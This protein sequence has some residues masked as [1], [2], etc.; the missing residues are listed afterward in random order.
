MITELFTYGTTVTLLLTVGA[1]AVETTAVQFGWSRRGIWVVTLLCSIVVPIA[2][3]VTPHSQ[4]TSLPETTLEDQVLPTGGGREDQDIGPETRAA[5]P[6]VTRSIPAYAVPNLDRVLGAIWIALS[7]GVT[8][9]LGLSWIRLRRARGTWR[10]ATIDG[11]DVWVTT[12][13]G[14]AV[15]GFFRPQILVP[16][17]LLDAPAPTRSIVLLHECEH[18]DSRDPLLLFFG[19]L[20]VLLTPWNLPLWWQLK[21]LRFAV[22]VD[23]DARVL[24]TGTPLPIYGDVLLAVSQRNVRAP[25]GALAIAKPQSELERRI[26]LMTRVELRPA[27][28]LIAA[29]LALAAACAAFALELPAPTLRSSPLRIPALHDWSPYLPKAE[30]AARAAYPELF[31]GRFNGTV[32]L[33]VSLKRDGA[34]LGTR[35][36]EFPPGPLADDALEFDSEIFSDLDRFDGAANRKFFGWFG[37][38]HRNGLYMYYQ[39]L[40]WPH[41]PTRSAARV[42]AA[43]AKQYPEFFRAYPPEQAYKKSTASNL[44]VF[45]NEDGTINRA[46]LS[47]SGDANYTGERSTYER[48]LALG[49]KPEQFGHRARTANFQDSHRLQRFPNAP[50]LNIFYAWPRRQDDPPDVVFQSRPTFNHTFDKQQLEI[51]KRVP[52][53]VILKRYFP[54]IWAHGSATPSD[55]AWIL[56]DRDGVVCDFGRG[57]MAGLES[58]FNELMK[59]YP[60]IRIALELGVGAKTAQGRGVNLDYL[61]LAEDSPLT[62]CQA[63]RRVRQE[64]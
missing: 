35:S 39:V 5:I 21:R 31:Q 40:K 62:S 63:I 54:D 29:A 44:T 49:L 9:A 26:R 23:C 58:P 10:R 20:P 55:V 15:L 47:E 53:E 19:Y 8:G 37:R 42:R 28:W 2:M 36:R 6:V 7:G 51:E 25:L 60:G 30:A 16:Q 14:P 57:L 61:R 13:L 22:E 17:W 11:R 3:I 48:F 33:V 43:V 4:V 56:T 41:D 24:R 18:I 50:P 34:V 52:D 38:Q 12:A 59:R 27:R 64:H 1:L 32:V 45:M 46:G